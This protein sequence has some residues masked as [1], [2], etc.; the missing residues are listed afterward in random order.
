[1]VAQFQNFKFE[2][3]PVFENDDKSFTYPDTK[4]KSWKITKPRDEIDAMSKSD[5]STNGNLRNLCRLA[6]AWKN[7]HGAVIGGLLIDTLA[8]NFF[9]GTTDYDAATT[10]SYDISRH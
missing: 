1:V 7:K 3:Q 10:S 5:E 9:Q 8:Y 4:T 2:V 6:R